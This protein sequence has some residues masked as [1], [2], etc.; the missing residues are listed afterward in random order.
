MKRIHLQPESPASRTTSDNF[1]KVLAEKYPRPFARW[2]FGVTSRRIKVDKT[3]LSREPIRADSVI[4]A[5]EE[6]KLHAEF[7]TTMKSDVPV[8]LRMLDYYVGFKRQDVAQRVR[9]VLIVLK[10]AGEPIPDRYEDERTLHHYD[11]I[12]MWEQD[13]KELLQFEELLPLATLCHTTSGEK[14]LR[15]VAAGINRIESKERQRETL[16][17]ARVLAGLRYD[18]NLIYR[19]L[20]EGSMLE[21]SVVYQDILQK[22]E[23]RGERKFAL[24]QLEERFGKLSPK[25]RKQIE[26]LS[27]GQLEELIKALLYFEGPDEL[28]TWL[29]KNAATG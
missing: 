22:G 15:A 6:G 11:V 17:F 29:K 24:L 3:E 23:Q 5:S 9:Q 8:P 2:A 18:T 10:E 27:A 14:L 20:K 7:Q 13:P 16:D 1:C 25:S 28:L 26:H 19:I 4:L 12:K 21:E